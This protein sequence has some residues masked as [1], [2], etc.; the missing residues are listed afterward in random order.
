[1]PGKTRYCARTPAR[2]SHPARSRPAVRWHGGTLAFGA[3]RADTCR[4]WRGRTLAFGRGALHEQQHGLAPRRQGAGCSASRRMKPSCHHN[5]GAAAAQ[6][7]KNCGRRNNACSANKP[8]YECPAQRAASR[9]QRCARRQGRHRL[10]DDE[11]EKMIGAAA[12]SARF[13]VVPGRTVRAHRRR[14]VIGAHRH[15]ETQ[16]AVGA[17]GQDHRR[18]AASAQCIEL[19]I[20][21][22]AGSSCCDRTG[23]F[24]SK[25]VPMRSTTGRSTDLPVRIVLQ[26]DIGGPRVRWR[27]SLQ[28]SRSTSRIEGLHRARRR[29]SATSMTGLPRQTI[30]A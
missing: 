27:K 7:E 14:V 21:E 2:S 16:I 19:C 25:G 9:I 4:R 15:V 6:R 17:D 1:M 13:L 12:W 30:D 22:R 10:G 28:S 18:V 23:N 3:R 29:H 5:E 20:A 24:R 26:A 11:V 8:P